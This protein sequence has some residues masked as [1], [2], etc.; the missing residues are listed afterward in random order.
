MP[1]LRRD[2]EAEA[3]P[4]LRVLFLGLGT[5][6]P[7]PDGARGKR[8]RVLPL[9]ERTEDRMIAQHSTGHESKD[10]FG[11]PLGAVLWWGL[12]IVIGIAAGP[13]QL[14][15]ADAAFIWA[16]AFAW[17]GTGC[18]LNARRCGRLHCFFSGPILWFGA[19]AAA[20]VGFRLLRGMHALN[21]VVWTTAVLALLSCVPELIWGK[22]KGQS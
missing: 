8:R 2:A 9:T 18:V 3:G 5:V 21:A 12:P 14:P 10:W 16:A 15:L 6:P 20:L 11:Q 19:L 17:M 22:Y 7:D 1:V 4:L 13:L